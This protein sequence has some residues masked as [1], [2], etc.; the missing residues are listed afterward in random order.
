VAF[1]AQAPSDYSEFAEFLVRDGI[2]SMSIDPDTAMKTT[3]RVLE[4]E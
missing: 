1:V 3:L 2:D 4:V